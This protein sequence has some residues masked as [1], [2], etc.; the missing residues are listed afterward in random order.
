MIILTLTSYMMCNFCSEMIRAGAV[1]KQVIDELVGLGVNIKTGATGALA[2][3]AKDQF[4]GRT[5]DDYYKAG[6]H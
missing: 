1:A 5:L 4:A 3:T 2:S 6:E